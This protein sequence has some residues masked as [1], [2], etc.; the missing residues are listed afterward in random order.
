MEETARDIIRAAGGR[1]VVGA[2]VGVVPEQVTNYGSAGKLPAAWFDAMER[3]T[4]RQLPRRLFTF[5]GQQ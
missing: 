3:L 5:K 2:A 4:G 1:H